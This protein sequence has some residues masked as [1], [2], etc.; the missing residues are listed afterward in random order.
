[1]FNADVREIGEELYSPPFGYPKQRIGNYDDVL[2]GHITL[3]GIPSSK[4]VAQQRDWGEESTYLRGLA[5]I[6]GESLT[7]KKRRRFQ[8]V[9]G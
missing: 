6:V 4:P 3:T 9:F 2:R 5:G 8:R 7:E 1:M